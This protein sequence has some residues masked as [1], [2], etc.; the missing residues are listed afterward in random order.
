M[1]KWLGFAVVFM[2]VTHSSAGECEYQPP[3]VINLPYREGTYT[4][5]YFSSYQFNLP[6][7]PEA[8]LSG[9]GFIASYPDRGYIGQQHVATNPWGVGSV[10]DHSITD[11][12]QAYRLIYGALSTK[13]L[14][15]AALKEV[16][17]QRSLLKLDC[18]AQVT[19]YRVGGS[20]DVIWQDKNSED[21]FHTLL[22]LGDKEAEI[23]TLRRPRAEVLQVIA[24][25][26]LRR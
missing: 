8:L 6:S 7:K 19:F 21:D 23:I 4:P 26:K 15:K 22:V 3:G 1:R 18:A 16:M 14:S 20:V 11:A 17:L 10:N 24:S 13:A 25:I 9:D 2:Y 12:A 5:V